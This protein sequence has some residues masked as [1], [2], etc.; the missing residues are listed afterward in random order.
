MDCSTLSVPAEGAVQ[1]CFC[2]QREHPL[3][4][5]PSQ[6]AVGHRLQCVPPRLQDDRQSVETHCPLLDSGQWVLA[7]CGLYC[8]CNKMDQL[9]TTT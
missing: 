2:Q 6:A 5:C 4:V 3:P 1:L 8:L 7:S 9:F